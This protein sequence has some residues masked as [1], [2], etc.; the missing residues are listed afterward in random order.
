MIE[1]AM[2]ICRLFHQDQPFEQMEA[3]LLSEGEMTIGRDPAADWTLT[4]S[5]GTLSRIHCI[6][7]LKDGQILLRD[8][9]TNGTYLEGG[10]RA[11]RDHAVALKPGQ[12]VRLGALSILVDRA[13]QDGVASPSATTLHGALSAPHPLV[14][15]DW[16]DEAPV[17]PAHRDTSLIE[18]FCEGARIDASELSSEDPAELMKRIGAIYQQTVLG[19]ATLMAERTRMKR[20]LELNRTTIGPSDNNPFKWAPTR[21]LAQD[22]LCKSDAGFLSDADAVRAS[23]EDLGRHL[24]AVV[25]GAN[26]ASDIAVRTLAPDAIDAE[27]RTQA[28]LLKSRSALCWDILTKRHAALV[29]SGEETLAKRA[30]AEGYDRALG[31][32]SQR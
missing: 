5:D 10:D 8:Q 17:R 28:S 26:A 24:T 4:D 6:L 19:L 25:Q 13:D 7:A 11:P 27:A 15:P 3:R 12:C 30:F 9:S 23:F 16:T 29:H 22:L 14:P 20:E 18:A 32:A 1:Q 2:F 21:K 31:A